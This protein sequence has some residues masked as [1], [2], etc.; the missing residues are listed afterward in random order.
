MN[1]TNKEYHSKK[2]ERWHGKRKEGRLPLK[3]DEKLVVKKQSYRWL[4]FKDDN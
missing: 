3:T 2:K 4:K 1:K